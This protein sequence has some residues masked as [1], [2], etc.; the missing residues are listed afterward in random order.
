MIEET[1]KTLTYTLQRVKHSG[2]SSMQAESEAVKPQQ[3]ARDWVRALSGRKKLETLKRLSP[4]LKLPPSCQVC[5][6]RTAKTVSSSS[7]G[8]K[9]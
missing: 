7:R 6:Q 1:N 3:G 2:Q 9:H 5:L 4:F 8:D